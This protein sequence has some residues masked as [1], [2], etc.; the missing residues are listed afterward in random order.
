MIVIA[1]LALICIAMLVGI[2]H[3]F[4]QGRLSSRS[5]FVA[6]SIVWG[7][8]LVVSTIAISST[9]GEEGSKT[10]YGLTLGLIL[11]AMSTAIFT[12]RRPK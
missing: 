6:A 2:N 4:R 1:I 5:V 11:G 8:P 10:C 9:P 12:A 3:L 7:I